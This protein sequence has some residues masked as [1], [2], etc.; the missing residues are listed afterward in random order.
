MYHKKYDAI[1]VAPTKIGQILLCK[2]I[3]APEEVRTTKK[4]HE[5]RSLN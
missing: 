4:R 2:G 5:E 1:N 3:H